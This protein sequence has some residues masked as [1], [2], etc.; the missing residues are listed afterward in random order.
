MNIFRNWFLQPL[1]QPMRLKTLKHLDRKEIQEKSS[2]ASKLES[3]I[4]SRTFEHRYGQL[5]D[6]EKTKHGQVY[7]KYPC[8][9]NGIKVHTISSNIFE[10]LTL[11]VEVAGQ[12]DA[13]WGNKYL[14]FAIKGM[15]LVYS[16]QLVLVLTMYDLD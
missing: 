11:I 14:F 12:Y 16:V 3:Q 13:L 7:T 15:L 1:Q 9:G 5:Y 2:L 4:T 8:F 6:L 10:F